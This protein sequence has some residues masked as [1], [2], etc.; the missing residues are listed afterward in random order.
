MRVSVRVSCFSAQCVERVYLFLFLFFMCVSV[1][2]VS[3]SV[4]AQMKK[5]R[6]T[7]S[8]NMLVSTAKNKKTK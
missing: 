6:Q 5:K 4:S 2:C 1:V 7:N 8:I 3:V